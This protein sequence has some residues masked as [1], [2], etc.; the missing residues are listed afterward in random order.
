MIPSIK[1]I[2]QE[3]VRR[4]S[5]TRSS[6]SSYFTAAERR[7]RDTILNEKNSRRYAT[8]ELNWYDFNNIDDHVVT[9]DPQ[10]AFPEPM[11]IQRSTSPTK[12]TPFPSPTSITSS[13]S[14]IEATSPETEKID[15]E[16]DSDNEER[17][18]SIFGGI[19]VKTVKV[20]HVTNSR[21][22]SLQP[23]Q[24]SRRSYTQ[25]YINN[26]IMQDGPELI[27][28]ITR[29]Y[30]EKSVSKTHLEKKKAPG[31]NELD[32]NEDDSNTHRMK[33]NTS[34]LLTKERRKTRIYN[35]DIKIINSERIL[36]R[37]LS[38]GVTRTSSKRRSGATIYKKQQKHKT[39]QIQQ[40]EKMVAAPTSNHYTN[41][42]TD[43]EEDYDVIPNPTKFF[44]WIPVPEGPPRLIHAS[45]IPLD[46]IDKDVTRFYFEEEILA[47][48]KLKRKSKVQNSVPKPK[49]PSQIFRQ[50]LLE[51]S[52][53][54]SFQSGYIRNAPKPKRSSIRRSVTMSRPKRKESPLDA[55]KPRRPSQNFR[56]NLLE[57]SIDMS[58]NENVHAFRPKRKQSSP[59]IA[60]KSKRPFKIFRQGVMSFNENVQRR[61]SPPLDVHKPKRPSQIFRQ[62]LLEQSI[63]MSF[64][65][66]YA[67]RSIRK[68]TSLSSKIPRRRFSRKGSNA[69]LN[70]KE[71]RRERY[72]KRAE[73]V[74]NEVTQNQAD[75]VKQK[76]IKVLEIPRILDI[77][78]LNK[79][80]EEQL[81]KKA[82]LQSPQ[83]PP[84][85]PEVE[86]KKVDVRRK[87]SKS[88][89][90]SL[91]NVRER[92]NEPSQGESPPRLP[93]RHMS[94][95]NSPIHI[96]FATHIVSSAIF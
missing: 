54:M 25:D 46:Q 80:V 64:N 52:L 9:E 27:S 11:I 55:P 41:D 6:T 96:P 13:S 37:S 22:N 32:S 35:H 4:L 15:N 47:R 76:P 63:A 29:G 12:T 30:P 31:I 20:V 53:A 78:E 61:Q 36:R 72:M 85:Q 51:Q 84:R 68:Q 10:G 73:K 43:M 42:P 44:P 81:R 17:Q 16:N 83:P 45:L 18:P 57:Q 74:I 95:Y 86:L 48:Y 65:N 40:E 92:S 82:C 77:D 71:A 5:H 69:K 89:T 67:V 49:R 79:R 33:Q 88:A 2:N 39:R 8:Y 19:T 75:K 3:L 94:L 50:N 58:P 66:D 34:A 24:P 14:S 59:L 62:N 28:V 23:L 26:D 21:H 70:D 1:E 38:N 91:I 87:R 7:D 90:F 93:S 60:P 56:Q